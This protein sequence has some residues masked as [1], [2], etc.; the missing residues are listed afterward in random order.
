MAGTVEEHELLAAVSRTH[1]APSPDGDLLAWISDRDGR[2][3]AFV[4][5]LPGDGSPVSEPEQ[6]LDVRVERGPAAELSP[7][8]TALAWSPDGRWLACQI[9]PAGGERSRVV[10]ADPRTGARR[11]IAPTAAAVTLGA[12]SPTGRML[13]VTIQQERRGDGAACLVD[14]RT[15]SST[16]LVTGV[17]AV[18]C[19][20]GGDGRRAVVRTGPRGRRRL[21][22]IDLRTGRR[23]EL[24]SGATIAAARFGV[25][26]GTLLLH[27]D[28]G[29]EHPA[30]LAASLAEDGD[31]SLTRIVAGREDS[32]L[33]LVALDPAGARAALVW[34][35]GGRSRLEITD[36]RGRQPARLPAPDP[37]LTG[38]VFTRDGSALLVAGNGPDTAPRV[39]RVAL[40]S[41]GVPAH[42]TPLLAGATGGAV[43]PRPEVF[44]GEDGLDLHGWVLRPPGADGPGPAFVWLHGGPESEERPGFAPL[45]QALAAAGITVFAP[46]VRGSSGRGRT[47]TQADD[48]DRREHSITD[49]RAAARHLVGAG[50]AD[51]DRIA[52]GGRSY[53]GY[54]TLAALTRFPGLFRAGVDIC[55]MADLET[56]YASSEP[57]VGAA[58]APEYGDPATQTALLRSLSPIHAADR[59]TVPLLV[60]HGAHDTNVPLGEAHR[61]VAA[62]DGAEV[63]AELV[64]F[65][66][67]GHEILD[68]RSRERFVRDTARW[69]ATTLGVTPW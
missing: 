23:T 11:E 67:E 25:T 66:D 50:I 30:L 53:G 35:V 31:V 39:S 58:A 9:A 37:I 36:L 24:A 54:L 22:L 69:L 2:P 46:N 10:L 68:R 64:I 49:V 14:V 34:N 40:P 41:P 52:V 29:R 4:A 27:T 13:G 42:T 33:D 21:E 16:V 5:P 44:T 61:I 43:P 45:L 60:V 38:V 20:I 57:W 19:A 15:E 65:D 7:D 62:L 6:A 28:A 56:F 18:V 1:P 12:W 59:I 32:D 63:P 17:A 47:F 3:R 55:G 26:G 48:G 8:V 51:P